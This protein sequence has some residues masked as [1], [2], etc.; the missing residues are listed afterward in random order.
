MP[1]NADRCIHDRCP[2]RCTA[3]CRDPGG[4]AQP[5]PFTDEDRNRLNEI[6][7][8]RGPVVG[9]PPRIARALAYIEELEMRFASQNEALFQIANDLPMGAFG[10]PIA[11]AQ[12]IARGAYEPATT[13]DSSDEDRALAHDV[14]AELRARAEKA[15]VRRSRIAARTGRADYQEGK[16]DALDEA[17]SLVESALPE[18][19]PEPSRVE[20]GRWADRASVEDAEALLDWLDGPKDHPKNVSWT[21]ETLRD[22]VANARKVADSSDAFDPAEPGSIRMGYISTRPMEEWEIE[23]AKRLV[24]EGNR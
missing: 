21:L 6:T 15:R 3:Y 2:H 22:F 16:A 13:E 17:A 24:E 7:L 5:D 20:W 11:R 19:P 9:D 14:A 18:S 12:E 23:H 8:G 10:T 1:R 4:P